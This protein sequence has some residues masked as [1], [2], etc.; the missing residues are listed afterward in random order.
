M[1]IC[2]TRYLLMQKKWWNKF[3]LL[4]TQ[5]LGVRAFE[6]RLP[7]ESSHYFWFPA[8]AWTVSGLPLQVCQEMIIN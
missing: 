4:V 3:E 1:I 8:Y 7:R 2:L 6:G 5:E